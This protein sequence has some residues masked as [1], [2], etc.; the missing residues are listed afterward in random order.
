MILD[1]LPDKPN[2]NNKDEMAKFFA[3][4]PKDLIIT[5]DVDGKLKPCPVCG[6]RVKQCRM[7]D[8][9]KDIEYIIN[10]HAVKIPKQ[11]KGN[12]WNLCME[13]IEHKLDT[14]D[15]LEA[16]NESL[17][18]MV[19]EIVDN[20]KIQEKE[21]IVGMLVENFAEVSDMHTKLDSDFERLAI[22]FSD[23]IEGLHEIIDGLE[24]VGK[25]DDAVYILL[26]DILVEREIF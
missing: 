24:K 7:S 15:S 8:S 16:E 18:E 4:E 9:E 14:Y 21:N 2:N 12:W 25:I 19:S 20:V 6:G 11:A 3:G 13:T 1:G 5:L 22:H 26:K 23:T 10:K 17:R